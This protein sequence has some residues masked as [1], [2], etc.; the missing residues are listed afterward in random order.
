M[1]IKRY[2][3]KIKTLKEK[4]NKAEKRFS[5]VDFKE[6]QKSSLKDLM[7]KFTNTLETNKRLVEQCKQQMLLRKTHEVE[8]ECSF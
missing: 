6:V 7:D 4:L 3:N 5:F 1:A 2:K 8:N